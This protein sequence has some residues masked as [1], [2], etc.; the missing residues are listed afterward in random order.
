MQE[1]IKRKSKLKQKV[2]SSRADFR[3][4]FLCHRTCK[5]VLIVSIWLRYSTS[6]TTSYAYTQISTPKRDF[7]TSRQ[8]LTTQENNL[9]Q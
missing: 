7:S 6:L 3:F 9:E 2:T 8:R 1:W 5:L 4:R